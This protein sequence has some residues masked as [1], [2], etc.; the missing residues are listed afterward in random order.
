MPDV[1]VL[2]GAMGT[3]LERRGVSAPA[4][5][6][7]AAALRTA[8]EI[9]T[10]IH[11]EYL[12]AG[13]RVLVANTFR[14]NPRALRAAGL[15]DE[16]GRT[17]TA[18]ALACAH[19]AVDAEPGRAD[20]VGASGAET[21]TMPVHT[22]EIRIVASIGPAADCYRP[23][24]VADEQT[25]CAEYG[26]FVD[27][28][29]AAGATFLWAE[30]INTVREARA[31]A[32]AAAAADLP[33]GVCFVTSETG[34]LLSGEPL[35]AAI[36]ACELFGPAHLGLNCIP[37]RGVTQQLPRLRRLTARPLAVY[38]H[39]CADRPLPGWSFSEDASPAQYAGY[40]RLWRQMGAQLIGG[41]CGTR[42]EHIRAVADD[43][44]PTG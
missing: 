19:A 3:E 37:P 10:A 6:W 14:T 44:R 11:R 32:R 16:E 12:W 36:E 22:V 4:P 23:D 25:L 21:G 8:P 40:A 29:R 34:A 27:W 39:L 5:L 35:A 41:C 9:V 17:L 33:F 18:R 26:V 24:L 13:A 2:D 20:R 28:L 30:T 38:A 7:S 42:P 43:A 1:I 31:I 15:T